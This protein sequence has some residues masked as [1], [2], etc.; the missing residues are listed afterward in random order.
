M[1]EHEFY[2]IH[3]IAMLNRI[4]S[5]TTTLILRCINHLNRCVNLFVIEIMR[6]L[7]KKTFSLI[8]A[9]EAQMPMQ[10]R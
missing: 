4:H 9:F 10:R 2:L 1:F 6:Y 3:D 8:D 7:M 5:I